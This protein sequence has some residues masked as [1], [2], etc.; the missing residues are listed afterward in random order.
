MHELRIQR[1]AVRWPMTISVLESK[2]EPQ[3]VVDEYRRWDWP[4]DGDRSGSG[5]RPESGGRLFPLGRL[6]STDHVEPNLNKQRFGA[7]PEIL[8]LSDRARVIHRNVVTVLL[9]TMLGL[10]MIVAISYGRVGPA[11]Q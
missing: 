4:L 8:G 2:P 5:S 11:C 10:L 6:E 9:T 7:L 1:W 3:F